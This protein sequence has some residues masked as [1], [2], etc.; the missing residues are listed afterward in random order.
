M[1]DGEEESAPLT[2]RFAKPPCGVDPE[3]AAA[4]LQRSG[5]GMVAST[6]EAGG[7]C[8]TIA[9]KLS[10]LAPWRIVS[11]GLDDTAD[12][13]APRSKRMSA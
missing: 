10:A 13:V 12:L 3:G 4:F 11:P 2:V 1:H 6:P 9:D 5:N 8:A 7:P